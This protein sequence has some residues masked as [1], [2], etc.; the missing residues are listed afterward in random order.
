MF[1][2]PILRSE[3]C[4]PFSRLRLCLECSHCSLEKI[5]PGGVQ[6]PYCANPKT[7]L[8]DPPIGFL[9]PD[10]I[11]CQHFHARRGTLELLSAE[12]EK[13]KLSLETNSLGRR[14]ATFQKAALKIAHVLL[15]TLFAADLVRTAVAYFLKS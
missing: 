5:V 10:E 11:A 4:T 1:E 8:F 6:I 9:E 12:R 13:I 3:S 14:I 2:L 7:K 15:L